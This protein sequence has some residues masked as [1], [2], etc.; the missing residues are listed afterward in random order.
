MTMYDQRTVFEKMTHSRPLP[1]EPYADMYK[2]G[3]SPYE[4]IETANRSIMRHH[5]AVMEERAKA[6]ESQ[7]PMDVNFNVETRIK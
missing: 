2:D 7:I 6:Q 5:Y 4:I 3:Y 1:D